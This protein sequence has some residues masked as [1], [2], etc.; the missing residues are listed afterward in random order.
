MVNVEPSTSISNDQ[1]V[2]ELIRG[3]RTERHLSL[4]TLAARSG[5]SP[6]FVSQV[7]HGQASPSIASLERMV[8]VLGVTLGEFF[9]RLGDAPPSVMRATERVKL[10]SAWS[11][12]KVEA[13]A[14]AGPTH[15]LEALMITLGPGGRSASHPMMHRTDAFALVLQGQVRLALDDA[16]HELSQ[17]DAVTMPTGSI[18]HW[19]NGHDEAAQFLVVSIRDPI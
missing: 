19:V 5:F 7:E 4:R 3:L 11:R 17:G 1:R 2:G 18:Y 12:A 6:S 10:S 15:T 16:V 13:L 8:R 9:H 14:P